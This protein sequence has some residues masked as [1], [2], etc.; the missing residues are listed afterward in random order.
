[1]KY[2]S[3]ISLFSFQSLTDNVG[4]KRKDEARIQELQSKL[5]KM[6]ETM[7]QLKKEKNGAASIASDKDMEDRDDDRELIYED[8]SDLREDREEESDTLAITSSIGALDDKT[9]WLIGQF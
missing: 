3:L 9:A 7:R 4:R 5:I 8:G 6:Q 1:M 2:Q